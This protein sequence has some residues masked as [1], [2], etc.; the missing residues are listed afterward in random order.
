MSDCI[1]IVSDRAEALA[2][3][4]EELRPLGL[5]IR[6][7]QTTDPARI[8]A[9]AR[10]RQPKLILLA[11][12]T[13]SKEGG[14]ICRRLKA[15]PETSRIRLM[16]LTGSATAAER[17]AKDGRS[18]AAEGADS[19]LPDSADGETLRAEVRRVLSAPDMATERRPGS[20]RLG[21]RAGTAADAGAGEENL[22]R[23]LLD[24]LP[25]MVFILRDGRVAY[26]N[27]AAAC[28]L[29][30]G[31]VRALLDRPFSDIEVCPETPSESP[32]S[33][34]GERP[35]QR[36]RAL[37]GQEMPVE[38]R[39]APLDGADGALEQVIGIDVSDRIAAAEAL[40]EKEEQLRQ[41]QKMEAIGRL[42]GGIAHDF[43]NLLTSI[44]GYSNLLMER[45][46]L[47]ADVRADL[48]EIARAGERAEE[49]TH[50]L[51]S[52]S[53]Q[54][55]LPAE[56]I[57][58]NEVIHGM[59]RLLRRTL[60]EDIELV[61]DTDDSIGSILAEAARIEQVIMNLAVNARDAMPRGGR[62]TIATERVTVDR[63]FCAAREGLRPGEC[64]RLEVADTGCGMTPEVRARAFEPFFTTKPRGQGTG[65]GLSTVYGIVRGYNGYIEV[66]SAP[67]R[68]TRFRIYFPL[69]SVGALPPKPPAT[70]P[71]P[72]GNETILLVEDDDAVR[73]LAVRLLESLGYTVL[74]ASNS[75]E[76][77]LIFERPDTRVDLVISDIV[78]PHISGVEMAQRLRQIRPDVRVLFMTGFAREAEAL[79]RLANAPVLLKPFTRSTLARH[80][81]W[82]LAAEPFKG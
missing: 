27:S 44:I 69:A 36:W 26:A 54:E 47:S 10:T 55:M 20:G 21:G 16:G 23:R 5:D 33:E 12:L 46:D 71:D 48:S 43:N 35:V 37:D 11:G 81:R 77:L 2:G 45:D 7:L 30:G 51:L 8:A 39:R 72:G 13:A 15:D 34:V 32:S 49:L 4:S 57:S 67:G 64:V 19:H 25:V 9:V 1:L 59:E 63:E 56:P 38:V 73:R 82:A 14:A 61:I 62:L 24:A 75:G 22:Y 53:H 31:D 76:A 41:A 66:D 50:R 29:A 3:Y 42:A 17:A 40:R 6:T 78:M 18:Y 80:V 52:F 68:G 58:L 74:E 79:P 65:I 70:A 28:R 60:G